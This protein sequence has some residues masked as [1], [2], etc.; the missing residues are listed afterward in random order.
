[1]QISKDH[2]DIVKEN[3]EGSTPNLKQLINTPFKKV[4]LILQI[5]SYVLIPGSPIIGGAI[6]SIIGL[7]A[8][9]SGG[10][11]LAIFILGEV[12][13]YFS[14][15]FLGKEVVKVIQVIIKRKFK[16]QNPAS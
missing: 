15:L 3:Q 12:L 1:M 16:K 9:Q 10:L 5:T 7:T 6:G 8:K 4:M 14:L 2:T 11:I 13:F